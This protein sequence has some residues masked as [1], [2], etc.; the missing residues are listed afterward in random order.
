MSHHAHV[1]AN[2]GLRQTITSGRHTLT[3]DEPVEAGGTD[4]GPGP[5]DFLCAGLGAC[6]S[7][8][9]RLYADRKQWPLEGMEVDVTHSRVPAEG[10]GVIEQF[11]RMITIKG[12]LDDDQRARLMEIAGK[13]PVH[14]ALEG[15]IRIVSQLDPAR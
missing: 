13:C 3:A 1:V 9:V 2:E 6:T 14:R 7:M 10:G 15:D 5:F 4:T 12:P 11:T 8:T